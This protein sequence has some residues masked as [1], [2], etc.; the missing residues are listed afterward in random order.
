MAVFDCSERFPSAGEWVP[1]GHGRVEDPVGHERRDLR[2][3]CCSSSAF[4]TTAAESA[5]RQRIG[6]AQ[7]RCVRSGELSAAS[8][9]VPADQVEN[10]VHSDWGQRGHVV[11]EAVPRRN[12][13]CSR[14]L[15]RGSLGL[16][17]D[18]DHVDT[19]RQSKRDRAA[20]NAAAGAEQQECR[21]G[22]QT[23][24][25]ECVVGRSCRNRQHC[26]IGP[27]HG[28]RLV[29]CRGD[30]EQCRR[31]VAAEA[32]RGSAE[33]FVADL[34]LGDPRTYSDDNTG[35]FAAQNRRQRH[36]DSIFSSTRANFPVS[37]VDARRS[38]RHQQLAGT[39]RGQGD[40]EVGLCV[41]SAVLGEAVCRRHAC[42]P[43][44]R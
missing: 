39:G 35:H 7:D 33:H 2:E 43:I 31:G 9:S 21:P 34:E 3:Y 26:G 36:R 6:D 37:G 23:E 1:P 24:I 8:E 30:V 32:G 12:P 20:T 25:V 27:G 38:D 17:R 5:R 10:R 42:Q 16:A 14:F 15:D 22:F 18:T 29:C 28:R 4:D 40:V 13:T 41:G 11:C 19:P 44:A